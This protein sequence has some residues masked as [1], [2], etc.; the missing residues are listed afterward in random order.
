MKTAIVA[1]GNEILSGKTINSNASLISQK[2]NSI[3][4]KVQCHFALRDHIAELHEFHNKYLSE[5]NLIFFTGGLGPTHDDMTRSF[6]A[7]ISNDH[8][9]INHEVAEDLKQR[10]PT[11]FD[12]IEEQ[13]NIPSKSK[14]FIN[15]A[16][17]AP[18]FSLERPDGSY[19]IFL[20]GVPLELKHFFEQDLFQYIKNKF[21]SESI[22]QSEVFLWGI[23]EAKIAKDL[24]NIEAKL[25]EVEIGSYPH[26]GLITLRITS[27]KEEKIAI[28]KELL[29]QRLSK[30]IYESNNGLLEE[31]VLDL[32]R[33]RNESIATAESCTGGR[34][35][36]KLVQIAGASDCLLGGVV[37]YSNQLKE[38]LLGVSKQTLEQWG[39]VSEQTVQGMVY[40]LKNQ[41]N[42]NWALATSGIAGP[43]G[44]SKDKPIGT[45]WTA[46]LTPKGECICECLHLSGTR[47]QIIKRT[48]VMILG[49]LYNLLQ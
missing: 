23:P 43:S 36:A 24:Q 46:I 45:V 31:A 48:V 37:A 21:G 17:T 25:P 34:I 22:H 3:G 5:F 35:A 10:Y 18:A 41:T 6:A 47:E 9:Q 20:P 15:K 27:E 26:Q 11:R 32:L 19:Y 33:N 29:K 44:G 16:G 1:I 8:L 40:G 42:C 7:L 13:A 2:L 49:K 30:H 39:A 12:L 38:S 28:A 14:A 4:I